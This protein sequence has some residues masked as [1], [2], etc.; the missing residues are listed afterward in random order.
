MTNKSVFNRDRPNLRRVLF[1]CSGNYYRSRHAE[2]YFNWLASRRNLPWTAFSRGL[3]LTELNI[4]PLSRHTAERLAALKIGAL[5]G[6]RLPL[7]VT[8]SDLIA[9]DHIV[10]LKGA[11]HRSMVGSAFPNWL[12]RVEF[13]EIHD[14]DCAPPTEALPELERHVE[15]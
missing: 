3:Q 2:E 4:G 10:A 5:Q 14:L 9:A 12:P 1:L 13:W 6:D 7:A 11:E 8:E 15:R